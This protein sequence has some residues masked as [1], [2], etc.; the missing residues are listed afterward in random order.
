MHLAE[1]FGRALIPTKTLRLPP[2]RGIEISG[3]LTAFE[4]PAFLAVLPAL[5][6]KQQLQPALALNGDV[7]EGTCRMGE[8]EKGEAGL[9]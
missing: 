4:T 6:P 3:S 7:G 8:Q 9:R 2:N 1:R 5:V